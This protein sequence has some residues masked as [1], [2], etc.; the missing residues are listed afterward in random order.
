MS[1]YLEYRDISLD[2]LVSKQLGPKCLQTPFSNVKMV[3]G[4]TFQSVQVVGVHPSS[5]NRLDFPCP[6]FSFIYCTSIYFHR[7]Q[8]SRTV[9]E[10]LVSFPAFMPLSQRR[11]IRIT[12]SQIMSS[13]IIQHSVQKLSFAA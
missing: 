2:Y 6:C 4:V 12:M 9:P 13:S 5:S 11:N 1:K 10:L 7:R 3:E 8:S